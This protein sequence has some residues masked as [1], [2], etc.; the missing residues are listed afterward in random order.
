MRDRK[1]IRGSSPGPSRLGWLLLS[2]A[3]AC[4]TSGS[5][6]ACSGVGLCVSGYVTVNPIVV[7][8]T[9]GTICPPVN[10]VGGT[11]QIGFLDSTAG[12]NT[13]DEILTKE[14]GLR[15][16]FNPLQKFNSPVNTIS[17]ENY[18]TTFGTL[19]FSSTSSPSDCNNLVSD[20]F[21]T[22][23]NWPFP[24]VSGSNPPAYTV[25]NP[26]VP[27]P[28]K[29]CTVTSGVLQPSCVPLSKYATTENVFFVSS[30]QFYT[31]GCSGTLTGFSQIGGNGVAINAPIVFS[32]PYPWDVIAHEIVHTFGQPHLPTPSSN[33]MAPGGTRTE[34]S[35]SSLGSCLGL[36]CDAVNITQST[37]ILDPVGQI[38]SI[39]EVQATVTA[40]QAANTY[41]VTFS[42]PPVANPP[43][44]LSIA[45]VFFIPPIPLAP[46]KFNLISNPNHLVITA[47]NFQ[48]NLGNTEGAI[49]CGPGGF[50]CAEFDISPTTPFVPGDSFEFSVQISNSVKKTTLASLLGSFFTFLDS[51]SFATTST[52]AS[53][54]TAPPC[55][56]A[57]PCLTADSQEP[58]L[59][60]PA[61]VQNAD[62][63]IPATQ[64]PCNISDPN[65]CPNIQIPDFAPSP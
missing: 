12:V 41:F 56:T 49:N 8:S 31:S 43:P 45:S 1:T 7:C 19:H 32:Q 14:L 22:L 2:C 9:D 54:S 27:G 37:Q 48:G 57:G 3:T 10:N 29:V 64:T 65:G 63:F 18:G 17:P 24:K 44:N 11:T 25:P 61:F 46:N 35:T 55:L 39:L 15:A 13:A 20:D 53:N 50:K 59:G 26:T 60:V 6:F 21:N 23:T 52:V 16:V 5:A 34:S 58:I 4:L 62:A 28:K 30:L 47:N 38:N 40:A 51:A 33:L 42:I 36:T